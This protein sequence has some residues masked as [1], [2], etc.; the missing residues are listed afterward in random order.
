MKIDHSKDKDKKSDKKSTFD[1]LIFKD[2]KD[3]G[4]NEIREIRENYKSYLD[5]KGKEKFIPK[6]E[7]IYHLYNQFCNFA[8]IQSLALFSSHLFGNEKEANGFLRGMV[9]DFLNQIKTNYYRGFELFELKQQDST[10]FKVIGKE[11]LNQENEQ[12][13][14]HLSQLIKSFEEQVKKSLNLDDSDNNIDEEIV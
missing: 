3:L 5:K 6:S 13:K 9:K 4:A 7:E 2:P 11:I 12:T 8:T 1:E 14:E 10:L